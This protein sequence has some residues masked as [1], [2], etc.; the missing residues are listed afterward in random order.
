MFFAVV[1]V[2]PDTRPSKGAEAVFRSTPTAF[3]Q[4]TFSKAKQQEAIAVL[5]RLIQKH[6]V[7]HI[8]I[9]NGTASRST[10]PVPSTTATLHPFR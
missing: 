4:P 1:A 10:F 5:S 2:R 9:G 8:A 6:G 7:A 3:T